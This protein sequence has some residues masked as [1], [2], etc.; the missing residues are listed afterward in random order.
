MRQIV[1]QV[2]FATG[3]PARRLKRNGRNSASTTRISG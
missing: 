1:I 2:L 3:L